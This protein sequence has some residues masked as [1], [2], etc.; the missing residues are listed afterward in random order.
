MLVLKVLLKGLALFIIALLLLTILLYSCTRFYRFEIPPPF[1]GS[2][3]YNPYSNIETDSL[4]KANFHAHSEAWGGLTNGH[5]SPSELHAAYKA[6]GY[7]IASISNYHQLRPESDIRVYEH[8]FN[9]RKS[10]KLALFTPTVSYVDFPFYQTT[11]HKQTI[12]DLLKEQGALVGI[13]HPQFWESHDVAEFEVL[14]NYEFIEVLN[15]YNISEK[16]WDRALST[17]HAAWILADDDTH[18]IE[19]EPTFIMW[20]LIFCG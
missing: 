5:N 19:H 10:H 2:K 3:I 15:H 14:D 9:I 12:I 11:S 7:R 18:D 6:K 8:G 1:A 13:A 20:T 4:Y 17:G 16:H